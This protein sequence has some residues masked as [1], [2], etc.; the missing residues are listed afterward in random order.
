LESTARAHILLKFSLVNEDQVSNP[1]LLKTGLEQL[2]KAL[3]VVEDK[4]I[5]IVEPRNGC[6]GCSILYMKGMGH[7]QE[8]VIV[9]RHFIKV[10]N[11]MDCSSSADRGVHLSNTL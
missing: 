1:I 7:L 4:A 10:A 8:A 9:K 3:L 5:S 2:G 6:L 11:L